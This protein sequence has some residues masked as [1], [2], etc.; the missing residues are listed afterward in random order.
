MDSWELAVLTVLDANSGYVT[1]PD[2]YS[3]YP[4]EGRGQLRRALVNLKARGLITRGNQY[5]RETNET[6]SWVRKA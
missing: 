5:D 1:Y 6:V 2:L 4:V 3:Q